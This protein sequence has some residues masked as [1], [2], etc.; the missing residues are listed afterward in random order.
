[1]SK[2]FLIILA[3]ILKITV[4][5][6]QVSGTVGGNIGVKTIIS[7]DNQYLKIINCDPGYPAD[8]SGLKVGDRIYQIDNK[9]VAELTDPI[10]KLEGVSG[11][12]VKL[13]I[14]NFCKTDFRDVNVPRITMGTNYNNYITEGTLSALI[15][16]G[17]SPYNSSNII[18]SIVL[19][20]DDSSD[21]LAYKTYDFEFT[22]VE[23]P[24]QEK[25]IFNALG[26]PTK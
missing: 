3:T 4:C 20:H 26:R 24:L 7:Q 15:F 11:S 6:S 8:I 23:E 2:I 5:L 21:M 9:K 19:L 14:S 17:W 12:W 1:M 22:S 16:R 10:R 18:S 25:V 13:T